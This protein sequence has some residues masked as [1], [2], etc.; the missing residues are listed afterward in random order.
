PRPVPLFEAPLIQDGVRSRRL[1][2][3]LKD[4]TVHDSNI[5]Q[6]QCLP[7]PTPVHNSPSP[8]PSRASTLARSS[9]SPVPQ[10]I[11]TE[12][13]EWGVYRM[14]LEWPS[15]QPNDDDNSDYLFAAPNFADSSPAWAPFENV[16]TFRIIDWSYNG[17][18]NS[19]AGLDQLVHKVIL[20]PDFDAA[21]LEN[22]NSKRA[23][24]T[25]KKYS[26]SGSQQPFFR[27]SDGWLSGTVTLRLPGKS[28]RTG[29]YC[30][31]MAAP[32]ATVANI[33]YRSL[34]EVIGAAF[35]NK[36]E[37]SSYN[38]KG[39]RE[40]WKPSQHEAPELMYGE[41]YASAEYLAMEADIRARNSSSRYEIVVVPIMKYS[42]ATHL[43]NFGTASL[44]PMY[45]SVGLLS[46][47]IRAKPSA[48]ASHHVLYFP[49]LPDNI[50]EA[51]LQ[52][53][54]R[55]PTSDM[56]TF[57]KRDLFHATLNLLFTPEVVHAYRHGFEVVCADNVKR[58]LFP[59]FFTYSADYPERV[60][61]ASVKS[62]GKCLCPRCLT[63]KTQVQEL[64]TRND[65]FRRQQLR[66]PTEALLNLIERARRGIFESGWTV[67]GASI[68]GM[69]SEN[70]WTPTRNAFLSA[71]RGDVDYFKMLAVDLM[72]EVEIGV[73]K[74]FFAH[75]VRILYAI[76]D[77]VVEELNRCYRAVPTFGRGTIR[78]FKNNVAAMKKLAARDFEDLIQ[79]TMPCFDCL[80]SHPY[81]AIIQD[82]IFTISFWHGYAKLR[83]HTESSLTMFD[84]STKHFGSELRR[85]KRQVC[86]KFMTKAT[87]QEKK[88]EQRA[89][90]RRA[91]SRRKQGLEPEP[92]RGNHVVKVE[93]SLSTSKLHSCG[94]YPGFIR[95]FGTTDGAS[96]QIGEHEHV[97]GKRFYKRTNKQNHEQQIGSHVLN[98]Q[99]L[100]QI[101]ARV[102]NTEITIKPAVE[103][104]PYTNPDAHYH[105]S[106]STRYGVDMAVWLN[107]SRGDSASLVNHFTFVFPF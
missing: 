80:F 91:E 96:T 68:E 78:R 65:H 92:A 37:F 20:A 98:E 47:Y 17:G 48:L 34:L 40:M 36:R 24:E 97:R 104:L 60:L 42:D 79:C 70:S 99:K 23:L 58:L 59:R 81:D 46:K 56:L 72:H 64:G 18:G 33:P 30:K 19:L 15:R 49:S 83:L 84:G 86:V 25:L 2:A 73:L 94:D 106:D 6:L 27:A 63:E 75:L 29:K 71:F 45:V 9:M 5:T 55:A 107:S 93:F 53:F 7:S 32:F 77:Q 88:R 44:W 85:F 82:V 52:I 31:E 4:F 11:V 43:A 35:Q 8:Q 61:I 22:F 41:V 1:P 62:M 57:L 76:N 74:A 14:Y 28:L 50:Q 3:A 95:N 87:P 10:T 105:I 26:A 16:T 12:P 100:A 67:N 21:H 69:L 102:D 38:L 90:K 13:N 39:F 54:G 89:V 103:P 66:Q 51:Y 101:K